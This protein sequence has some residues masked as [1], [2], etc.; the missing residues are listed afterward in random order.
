M[1][2]SAPP[3]GKGAI[4]GRVV[5]ADG[6]PAQNVTVAL[7]GTIYGTFTNENGVYNLANIPPGNHTLVV[8]GSGGMPREITV[9]V[10]EDKVTSMH[11]VEVNNL[12]EMEEVYVTGKSESRRKQ[13]QAYAISVLDVKKAY[14]QATPLNKLLNNISS[15]RV[16]ESGGVGSDYSFSLNGFS[17]NQV[18]FF[19]DGIPMD[20]FGSSFN[21]SS[22]SIGMAER[23]EVYKGILPV[24][25]GGDALGGAVNIVSRKDASYLDASYSVGSFNTHRAAVNGAYTHRKTGFTLRTNAFFSYSDNDYRVLAP[26]VDL[27]TN[28]RTDERW[29]NRFHDRYRSAGV[30][31]EAGL[32][33]RSFADYLLAG[34]ILAAN[35]KDVQTGATMDA[36][37]GG[38]QSESR[39][40]IPS[41]RYKK[42]NLLTE[43]LTL[44]LHGAYSSVSALN[45]DTLMR[46]Y[47]WLG[48]WVNAAERGER[49]YTDAEIS[50]GEWLLN[51]S[52]DYRLND[53]HLISLNNMSSLAKRKVFDK[54]DPENESN[55]I[56]Q[57]LT[58]NVTGLSWQTDYKRWSA[59]IFGKLYHLQSAS[60]KIKDQYK[61][62]QR[63]EKIADKKT[64]FGYGAAWTVFILPKLQAKLSYEHAYRL[65]ESTEMFGD[66][67]IQQRNPD[68]KP[69]NSNNLNLGITCEQNIRKHTFWLD[70]NFIYRNTSDF[71][72]KGVSVTANPTTGYENLGN[73][74]TKGIEGGIRY[75]WSSLLDIG[76]NVT[77]QDIT[78]NQRFVENSGSYVGGSQIE[79]MTYGQRLPNIPYLFGHADVG[80]RFRNVGPKGSEMTVDYTF[81]YVREYYL[82][83]PGLGSRSS[84]NVIPEQLSHDAALG[85]SLENGKYSVALE[86]ANLTD[87][88]LY[89]HY[90]LQKPGRAFNLKLRYF[91]K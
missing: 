89:D 4:T 39:S 15:V 65:P 27:N 11:D 21:L 53:Y 71:I 18:K 74:L 67:L 56:P 35:D 38:V 70:A 49:Y 3:Q 5:D 63:L 13:E 24:T 54:A 55:K 75:R 69:E 59:T 73:V 22:I 83:F 36:V 1:Y 43:G 31:L 17:G 85:Y 72:R 14:A 90:R 45:A 19:L 64:D 10:E 40:F 81:S 80:L 46:K 79:N 32:V 29:V 9:F 48:E 66:G 2:S 77:Y 6:N 82:S 7:K 20:N 58:K 78:D 86:C 44:L 33:D 25:L 26:I 51:A 47:S 12:V 50:S 57:N 23:I 52:L 34:V 42:S 76:A 62:T 61:E 88:K 16:R 84:K 28:Q 30:K 37:Y 68:L 87:A 60:Y 8:S 91:L 41:L